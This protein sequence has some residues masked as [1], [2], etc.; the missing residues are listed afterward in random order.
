MMEALGGLIIQLIIST[1]IVLF[2]I[3]IVFAALVNLVASIIILLVKEG[4][5]VVLKGYKCISRKV[6]KPRNEVAIKVEI[7]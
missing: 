7:E 3:Q 6:K 1:V 4:Y 5:A 2:I